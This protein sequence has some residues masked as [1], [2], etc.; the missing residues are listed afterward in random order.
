MSATVMT[1]YEIRNQGNEALIKALGPV[2]MIRYLQQYEKGY[3]NYTEERH[4]WLDKLDLNTLLSEL[5][6]SETRSEEK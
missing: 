2:G 6:N 5:R 1:L 3:G 4:Q